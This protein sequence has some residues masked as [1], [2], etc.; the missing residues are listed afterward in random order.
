MTSISNDL[1]DRLP[2][3]HPDR[4]TDAQKQAAAEFEAARRQPVFGPFTPLLRSPEL[5]R[6]AGDLGEYL[7]YRNSLPRQ[8]S[9]LAILLMARRWS[10]EYE[11]FVHAP[12]AKAAGLSPDIIQ[13]VAE[14]RR[15]AQMSDDQTLVYDFCTEL[16]EHGNVT[17][18][19]YARVVSRFGEQGMMDLVGVNGYYSFISMVLAV[20]RTPLPPGHAPALRPLPK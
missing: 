6:L 1:R 19:T 7:R 8:L 18:D 10:Q 2:P 4:M 12:D 20:A 17:D 3:I 5:M 11:W 14:G 13:A 16:S 9:E 15:P